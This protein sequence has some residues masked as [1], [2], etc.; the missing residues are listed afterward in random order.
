MLKLKRR[1]FEV[2]RISHDV[3]VKVLSIHGGTVEIGVTAPK[4]VPVHRE[5]IYKKIL[6]ANSKQ[7]KPIN[8]IVWH[9]KE[10]L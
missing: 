4:N 8:D 1:L 2:I 3:H 9:R 6:I 5:E 10:I 7:N